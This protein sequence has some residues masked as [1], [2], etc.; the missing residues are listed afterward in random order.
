MFDTIMAFESFPVDRYGLTA[1]TDIAGMRLVEVTGSDA[2]H[3]PWAW[4]GGS[5]RDYTS[6][7][8]CRVLTDDGD[9]YEPAAESWAFACR[10]RRPGSPLAG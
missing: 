8:V 6:N 10:C 3:Y 2:A 4:L 7:Q 9:S 5:T 1:D